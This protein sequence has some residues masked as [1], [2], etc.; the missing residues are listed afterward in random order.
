VYSFPGN[1]T[2][3]L[4]SVN[5]CDSIVNT[6]LTIHPISVIN[7]SYTICDGDFVIVGN[8]TYLLE[9]DYTDTLQT[10]HGCDSVLNT[11]VQWST[12]IL[13]LSLFGININAS[14]S[15]GTSPFIFEI[16][17]PSGLLSSTQNNGSTIQFNPL[18]NGPYYF[19]VTDG[20]GCISDTAFININHMPSF[21]S[22][23][24]NFKELIKIIDILG[25]EVDYKEVLYKR[26]LFYIYADGTVEKK[27]IIK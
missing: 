21:I 19:I 15:G 1:Y 24:K 23:M 20:L 9:G 3:I 17:G 22:D 25:R 12:P 2:D 11:S 4:T 14:L 10:I 8:N 13:S 7:N 18:I 27:I 6:N 26:T 5:G 16:Y